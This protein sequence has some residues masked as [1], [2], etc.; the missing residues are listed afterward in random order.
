MAWERR[1]DCQAPELQIT[2]ATL[3][4]GPQSLN[5]PGCSVETFGESGEQ[6]TTGHAEN[7]GCACPAGGKNSEPA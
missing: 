4:D 5:S 6:S 3:G 7:A 1:Q 2:A